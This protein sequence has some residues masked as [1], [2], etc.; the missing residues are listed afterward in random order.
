MEPR[1]LPAPERSPKR[2]ADDSDGDVAKNERP[3]KIQRGES[4]I[5]GAAGRRL[6]DQ[7]RAAAAAAAAANK[8]K[9]EPHH[10]KH[11]SLSVSAPQPAPLPDSIV[12]LL[13]RLPPAQA[14][15]AVRF[16]PEEMHKLLMS[17]S[18]P[19][20][21]ANHH[22][23]VSHFSQPFFSGLV[24][25]IAAN[26]RNMSYFPVSQTRYHPYAVQTTADSGNDDFEEKLKDI[27]NAFATAPNVRPI[28]P[29][30]TPTV[31]LGNADGFIS[32]VFGIEKFMVPPSNKPVPTDSQALASYNRLLTILQN[33]RKSTSH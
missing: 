22:N 26:Q 20:P 16:N 29:P 28:A 17:I 7:K 33:S 9:Q 2:Q 13:S 19:P 1:P 27:F 6:M 14:Y 21:P 15:R 10:A 24:Q 18:V 3:R 12:Y 31:S 5:K 4:P 11:P 32:G 25:K 30:V 23:G 8:E